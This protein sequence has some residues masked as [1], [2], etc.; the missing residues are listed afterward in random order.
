VIA[1]QTTTWQNEMLT[2]SAVTI[3]LYE[4]PL[5]FKKR[6]EARERDIFNRFQAE[7][8]HCCRVVLWRNL[9]DFTLYK[10]SARRSHTVSSL[11]IK[12][13]YSPL[14][15]LLYLEDTHYP[16]N[17]LASYLS[18]HNIF[19]FMKAHRGEETCAGRRTFTRT[20]KPLKRIC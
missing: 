9:S 6:D 3:L 7:G 1:H 5:L 15:S 10:Y 2:L 20:A 18:T 19:P 11:V 16:T 4:I 13:I 14:H 8:C 12:E 17:K